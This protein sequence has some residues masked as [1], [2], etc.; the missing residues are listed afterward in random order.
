MILHSD[1]EVTHVS[2]LGV[3]SEARVVVGS[4]GCFHAAEGNTLD[5]GAE[6]V[7][8]NEPVGFFSLLILRQLLDHDAKDVRN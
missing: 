5:S 4:S 6:A 8:A 1:A 2:W 7:L 3:F